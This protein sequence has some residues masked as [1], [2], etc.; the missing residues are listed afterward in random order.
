MR[1]DCDDA[2]DERHGDDKADDDEVT[3]EN[4]LIFDSTFL[5]FD[6]ARYWEPWY[7]PIG[8]FKFW[9]EC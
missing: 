1:D 5:G 8:W 9:Y 6:V 4:E 2:V 7:T 3:D